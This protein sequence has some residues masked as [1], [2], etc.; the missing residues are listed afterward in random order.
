MAYL[1]DKHMMMIKYVMVILIKAHHMIYHE[2]MNGRHMLLFYL[3]KKQQFSVHVYG[4][5]VC[6][7]QEHRVL[8]SRT[9][10]C[11][12]LLKEVKK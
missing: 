6:S 8:Y 12:M 7:S 11:K 10:Y 3:S 9:T 5:M 4:T 1:R 2:V